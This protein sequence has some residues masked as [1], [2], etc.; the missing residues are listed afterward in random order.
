[1]LTICSCKRS[2][3]LFKFILLNARDLA[4]VPFGDLSDKYGCLHGKP[5]SQSY[6]AN[7]LSLLKGCL[8]LMFSAS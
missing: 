6:P 7:F 8:S 3:N 2:K 4:D 1:M 5:C